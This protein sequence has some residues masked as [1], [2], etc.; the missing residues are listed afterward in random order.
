MDFDAVPTPAELDRLTDINAAMKYLPDI[1]DAMLKKHGHMDMFPV[2]FEI[3]NEAMDGG[4]TEGDLI[5]VSGRSG[6]GKTTFAQTMTYHLN[7]IGIP[8]AW[9]SY[10]M[11]IP[12]LWKKFQDMGMDRKN[13]MGYAP[14]KHTETDVKWI[15]DRIKEAILKFNIKVAFIDHLGFLTADIP[16]SK[17]FDRNFSSYLGKLTRQIKTIAMENKITI[18]LLAHTRKTKD[19]L[20]MED[21]AH[22][23]GIP[24]ESDFVFMVERL[25]EGKPKKSKWDLESEGE[26]MSQ[27]TKISMVKNRRTGQQ[28]FIKAELKAGRL[29]E[30]K[31]HNV[32]ENEPTSYVIE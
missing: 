3:F 17:D 27:F 6:H 28:K 10:E 26:V 8:V 31:P 12:Q 11:T 7:Q 24:Q 9:F 25:P 19:D 13:F 20:T 29:Q 16:Q 1:S 14:T 2:G 4:L 22:S 32:L 5:V 18:V 21:I 15:E 23:A 30:V